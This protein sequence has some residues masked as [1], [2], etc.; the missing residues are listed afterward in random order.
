MDKEF[1]IGDRVIITLSNGDCRGIVAPF[2]NYDMENS[3]LY[4]IN[5]NEVG[6]NKII[7]VNH[8]N[9][10]DK[11]FASCLYIVKFLRMDVQY[12]REERLK[13]LLDR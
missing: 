2:T 9:D 3:V 13:K 6:V 7:R 11:E 5:L 10:N 12:Y 1:N 4:S 8:I